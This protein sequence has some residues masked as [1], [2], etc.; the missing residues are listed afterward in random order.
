MY[1]HILNKGLQ[2][3]TEFSLVK[4]ERSLVV[5]PT[6][7]I[8]PGLVLYGTCTLCCITLLLVFLKVKSPLTLTS[9]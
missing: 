2:Q 5:V 4:R 8:T 9:C 3:D 1:S 6:Y 7:A